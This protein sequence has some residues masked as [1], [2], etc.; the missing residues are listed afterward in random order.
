MIEPFAKN[1]NGYTCL[2]SLM[3][4]SCQF[5]KPE[6]EGLGL[7]WPL[8][9]TPDKYVVKLQAYCSVTNVKCKEDYTNYGG[10]DHITWIHVSHPFTSA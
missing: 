9:G 2:W 8:N 3:R 5:M 10:G 1:R 4:R 7:D 6:S